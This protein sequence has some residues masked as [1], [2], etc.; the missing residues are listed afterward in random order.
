MK[1]REFMY[2]VYHYTIIFA[3]YLYLKA[4]L[5]WRWRYGNDKLRISSNVRENRSK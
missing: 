5:K 4:K 3:P 1:P 2:Y